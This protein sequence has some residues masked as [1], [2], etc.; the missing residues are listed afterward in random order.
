MCMGMGISAFVD[1]TTSAG[2]VGFGQASYCL[3]SPRFTLQTH[4]QGALASG[5]HNKHRNGNSKSS[6]KNTNSISN[7]SSTSNQYLE[8]MI[9]EHGG[10]F[11]VG[12]RFAELRLLRRSQICLSWKALH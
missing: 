2:T 9:W 5:L 6:N 1:S 12:I 8:P 3:F 11:K 10:S 7:S 4:S